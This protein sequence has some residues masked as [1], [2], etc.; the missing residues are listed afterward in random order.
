[1]HTSKL[2]CHQ[3]PNFCDVNY[4]RTAKGN[5]LAE[6]DTEKINS[7]LPPY[8]SIMKT[9]ASGHVWWNRGCWEGK[10]FVY[11]S[12]KH[13]SKALSSTALLRGPAQQALWQG[14]SPFT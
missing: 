14:C 4:I 12:K 2:K 9:R 1:M 13:S 6:G 11:F 7:P 5:I 3:S 10:A 8:D